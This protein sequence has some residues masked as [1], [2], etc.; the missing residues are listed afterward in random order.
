[1]PAILSAKRQ[2]WFL[3]MTFLEKIEQSPFVAVA[4]NQAFAV[5]LTDTLRLAIPIALTQLGQIAMM[6]T[7]LALIGRLGDAAVAAAARAP[8]VFLITI[9]FGCGPR[10]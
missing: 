10:S 8:T 2:C 4:P 9:T 7:D 3:A 6:T 1:V 5:E